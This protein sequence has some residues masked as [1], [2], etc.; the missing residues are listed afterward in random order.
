[1]YMLVTYDVSTVDKAGEKR[2][3]MVAKICKDYGQRVQKSVFEMKLDPAEWAICSARLSAAIDPTTDSLR[4]YHLGNN[5][6]QRIEHV[7][8]RQDFDIDGYLEI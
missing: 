7:G 8:Q 2:L 4:F 1:M 6:S 5:W 3:R